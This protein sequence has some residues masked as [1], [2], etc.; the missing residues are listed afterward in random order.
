[1]LKQV[2][3]CAQGDDLRFSA[4]VMIDGAPMA[5]GTAEIWFTAKR[6]ATDPDSAALFQVSTEGGGIIILDPTTNLVRIHVPGSAT[7]AAVLGRYVYDLRIKLPTDGEIQTLATGEI[8][9]DAAITQA[10]ETS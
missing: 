7:A 9:I 8:F 5:L 2:F 1:M 4:E 6:N 10:I 3:R